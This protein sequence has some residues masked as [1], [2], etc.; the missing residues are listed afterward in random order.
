MPSCRRRSLGLGRT[1]PS[2]TLLGT[3]S[4]QAEAETR[5]GGIAEHVCSRLRD[6]IMATLVDGAGVAIADGATVG[7]G[8]GAQAIST[9]K[10]GAVGG[11]SFRFVLKPGES[12]TVNANDDDRDNYTDEFDL[13][14]QRWPGPAVGPPA[15]DIMIGKNLRSIAVTRNGR[16]IS[17][18]LTVYRY[19]AAMREVR[20]FVHR[21]ESALKN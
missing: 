14:L 13:W 3:T 5:A 20:A 9:W 12:N 1:R 11:E 8:V 7:N 2:F 15:S 18:V 4:A 21:A 17:V 16:R 19:D 10:G 6:G